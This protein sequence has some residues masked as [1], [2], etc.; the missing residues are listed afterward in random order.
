MPAAPAVNEQQELAG[1][2]V[3][4]PKP[5]DNSFVLWLIGAGLYLV[6]VIL[7]TATGSTR[8]G[9]ERSF[10]RPPTDAE[11]NTAKIFGL[12]IGLAMIGLF[13]LFAFMMRAGRNW[14]RITLTVLGGISIVLNLFGIRSA[15]ALNLIITLVLVVLV[16]AAIYLMYRPESNN[17]FSAG[18]VRQ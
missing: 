5:V 11:V 13:V 2:A 12:V 10:G 7:G 6:F 17:Y 16:A 4:R 15:G 1:P 9:L 18:R 8:E 3:A 14:A